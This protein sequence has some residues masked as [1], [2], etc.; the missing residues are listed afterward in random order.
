MFTTLT[1]HHLSARFRP[2]SDPQALCIWSWCPP[3]QP[4]Q[5]AWLSTISASGQ[6]HHAPPTVSN[7]MPTAVWA[8]L[9]LLPQAS[10]TAQ[11]SG[12]QSR[13]QWEQYG[14]S[15]VLKSLNSDLDYDPVL[16][17]HKLLTRKRPALPTQ[18]SV[19]AANV[20]DGRDTNNV[21]LVVEFCHSFSWSPVLH[22][23]AHKA[24]CACIYLHYNIWMNFK[25]NSFM[26]HILHDNPIALRQQPQDDLF[27]VQGP[28]LF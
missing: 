15:D 16:S 13:R 25:R 27:P 1:Y 28:F 18:A 5:Q 6:E 14:N 17:G 21:V 10:R 11:V 2:S 12:R 20:S 9:E 19:P 3:G 24:L 8:G 22:Y 7:L 23:I 4:G 26:V